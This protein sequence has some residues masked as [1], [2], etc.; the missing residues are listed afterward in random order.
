LSQISDDSVRAANIVVSL[1]AMAKKAPPRLAN[2]DIHEAIQEVLRLVQGQ[3]MSGTVAVRGNF[4]SGSLMVRGDRILL[5]QVIMNLVLN[6]CEAMSVVV[7]R[8]KTIELK[9]RVGEDGIL[10]VSVSDNGPGVTHEVAGTLFESFV[11][12]KG[13]GMGMGLSICKSIIEAHGGRMEVVTQVGCG[14]CFRFSV[15]QS[16]TTGKVLHS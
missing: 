13:S 11:T 5:Q 9:T 6:A 16:I 3:L 1:R 15:P 4:G 8:E 14:A 10:W 12:T 2:M 7:G